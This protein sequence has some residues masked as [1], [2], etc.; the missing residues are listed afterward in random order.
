MLDAMLQLAGTGTEATAVSPALGALRT[1]KAEFPKAGEMVYVLER[2]GGE[3]VARPREVDGTSRFAFPWVKPSGSQAGQYGPVIKRSLNAKKEVSP[4]EKILRTTLQDFAREAAGEGAHAPIFRA[5]LELLGDGPVAAKAAALGAALE[6]I[7]SRKTVFVSIGPPP[8]DDPAYA[9]YLV[10]VVD[11]RLYK[12]D[13][14]G[15]TG[16]RCPLCGKE[17]ALTASGLVGAGINFFNMDRPGAFPG[18]RKENAERRF[19]L[20]TACCDGL[21]RFWTTQA[22]RLSTSIAGQRA[23]LLPHV[24]A[25]VAGPGTRSHKRLDALVKAVLEGEGTDRRE[26]WLLRALA[27]EDTLVAL[28]IV[29]ATLGQS[30]DDVTGV[31]TDVP[32]T[33]LRALSRRNFEANRWSGGVLP[34]RLLRGEPLDL[35]LSLWAD[36]LEHPGGARTRRTNDG[37][38]I[39]AIRR[40]L[41]R[42]VYTGTRLEAG[43]RALWRELA[44]VAEDYLVEAMTGAGTW[45]LLHEVEDKKGVVRLGLAGWVRHVAL[46]LCYLR[47]VEVI[48]MTGS[49]FAVRSPLIAP[50]VD[51]RSG[52]DTPEKAF[53]FLLGILFGKLM[54]VQAARKVNVQSNALSWLRRGNLSGRELPG[55]YGR[56]RAKLLEYGVESSAAVREVVAETSRIGL[57]LGDRIALDPETT[58][59][60]LLLG[61]ALAA[62]V[63]PSKSSEAT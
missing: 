39:A 12:I 28:H 51:E 37:A 9:A 60:F 45:G 18:I 6:T 54:S 43:G 31:V 35:S 22:K 40:D 5:A 2:V 29:W 33:R 63:L 20:C 8:G 36:L 41:A 42:A 32:S 61:Q 11:A 47:S 24:V 21:R 26:D 23:L 17:A 59:Y 14:D 1:G 4:G 62:E 25:G 15:A 34:R 38:R 50:L 7:A 10:G 44:A 13:G 57:E 49:P 58:I 27:E 48:E 19:A 46:G 53:A 52:V 56:V 16:G 30:L 55:L 3:L